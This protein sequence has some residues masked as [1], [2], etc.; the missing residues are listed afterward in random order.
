[1]A[2]RLI[3]RIERHKRERLKVAVF[4]LRVSSPALGT[5]AAIHLALLRKRY[6]TER[7]DMGKLG[8]EVEDPRKNVRVC[9][10]KK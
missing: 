1:M 2:F 9:V 5:P 8:R 3:G 6:R 4:F 7:A 10:R